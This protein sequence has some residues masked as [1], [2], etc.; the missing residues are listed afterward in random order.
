MWA[1]LYKPFVAYLTV[2]SGLVSTEY[3]E[4]TLWVD[5]SGLY[6]EKPLMCYL[7][8]KRRNVIS[9]EL[10]STFITV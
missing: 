6:L 1:V 2:R 7:I 8:R 5:G 10:K 4:N 3:Y 9:V